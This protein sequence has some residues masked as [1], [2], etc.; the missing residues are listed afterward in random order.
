MKPLTYASVCSGIEC[1]SVA[2]QGLPLKPIFFSEIE[3][4]PCAVLKYHYPE[5]PNFG[6]MTKITYNKET[7]ELTNGRTTITLPD[8]GIDILAGGTPCQDFSLA[9]L[10]AGA[11]GDDGEYGSGTRSS[12]CFHYCRLLREIQ[13]RW[14][15]Y[16]NVPGML[17]SNEGRDFAHFLVALGQSGYE[18]VSWRV[19]DAQYVRVDGFLR[20]VPQ[21]RRRV[22][23]VGHLGA[24]S[25]RSAEVLLEPHRVR[26]DRP[27]RRKTR[28]ELAA[29]IGRGVEVYDRVVG[30]EGVDGYNTTGTGNVA[31]T[32]SSH[33]SDINHTGGRGESRSLRLVAFGEYSDDQTA[34]T[35][36][37][38]DYKDITDIVVT[39][40]K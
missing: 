16:E 40:N 28:E 18:D 7:K 32:V 31:M 23:V 4:Y 35:M 8:G 10:R 27:P 22:W 17:T 13:P 25:Q 33:S 14:F 3:P 5:V 9:G 11:G 37:A 24:A 15:I 30:V 19:L 1:M 34:S 12:L 21:R 36:K 38:R 39:E 26:G 6:D 29:A 2:A 20:A